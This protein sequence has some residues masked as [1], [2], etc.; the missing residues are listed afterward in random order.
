MVGIYLRM[1]RSLAG[2]EFSPLRIEFR[3]PRPGRIDDFQSVCARHNDA[4]A[5]QYMSSRTLRRKLGDAGTTYKEVYF[6]RAFRRWTGQSPSSWRCK[7]AARRLPAGQGNVSARA[8]RR[9]HNASYEDPF[10]VPSEVSSSFA[11]AT[12]R[13]RTSF[14]RNSFE[15]M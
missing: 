7:S 5:L 11:N 8:S 9:A 3:R 13:G 1:C 12:S 4:I 10:E 15:T 14:S 2:R 6:T